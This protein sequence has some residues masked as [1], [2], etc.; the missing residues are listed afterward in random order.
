MARFSPPAHRL[1]G[2]PLGLSRSLAAK[3]HEDR[4]E[5]RGGGEGGP[6]GVRRKR[7]RDEFMALVDTPTLTPL[8]EKRLQELVAISE[9]MASSSTR[10]KKIRGGSGE[11]NGVRGLASPHPILGAILVHHTTILAA[12][13]P[14]HLL[15]SSP[16]HQRL[17][18]SPARACVLGEGF[19]PF[20]VQNDQAT[21]GW[22]GREGVKLKALFK[23]DFRHFLVIPKVTVRNG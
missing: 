1:T 7:V 5:E 16:A 12:G 10:R 8:E 23:M 11:E 18:G 4:E 3:E 17:T 2:S 14:A 19:G 21:E 15:T 20:F 13:P 22:E 6:Q 9:A